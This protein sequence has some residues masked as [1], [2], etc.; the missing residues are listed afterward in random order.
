[1]SKKPDKWE[2]E[3]YE[4]PTDGR[5]F[6]C[7][8]PDELPR[9]LREDVGFQVFAGFEVHDHLRNW[10]RTGNGAHMWRAFRASLHL[11]EP[12]LVFEDAFRAYLRTCAKGLAF[13]DTP[14]AVAQVMRFSNP[15]GGT[16][17]GNASADAQADDYWLWNQ[18]RG[19]ARF[20]TDEGKL[21]FTKRAIREAL[22]RKHGTTE[23]AIKQ[24]LLRISGKARAR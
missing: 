10:D 1:M 17:E 20:R 19:L 8:D 18:Y 16:G 12:D 23:G 4:P 2:L 5:P 3:T 21:R 13:A 24:R 9:H 14:G 15:L 11:V 6:H 22:A 7:I